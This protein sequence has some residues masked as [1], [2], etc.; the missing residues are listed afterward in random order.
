MSTPEGYIPT[1]DI[2]AGE[3]SEEGDQTR[4]FNLLEICVRVETNYEVWME[5]TTLSENLGGDVL[6]IL[7]QGY[8][9]PIFSTDKVF[10]KYEISRHTV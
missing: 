3:G 4:W 6:F 8:C 10:F 2:E 7:D 9:S 1:R 5:T